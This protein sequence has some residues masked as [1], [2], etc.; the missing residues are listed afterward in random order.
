MDIITQWVAIFHFLVVFNNKDFFQTNL[1]NLMIIAENCYLIFDFCFPLQSIF[2]FLI[3]RE[4]RV[5][6]KERIGTFCLLTM[7]KNLFFS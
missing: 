6:Y 2:T 5:T 7:A 1:Y 4:K 3:K